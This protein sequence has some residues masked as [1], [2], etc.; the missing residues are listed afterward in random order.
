MLIN[1]VLALIL[2]QT[3]YITFSAN[4]PVLFRDQRGQVTGIHDLTVLFRVISVSAFAL[5]TLV[6]ARAAYLSFGKRPEPDGGRRF[7]LRSPFFAPGGR[8][9]ICNVTLI[10]L[11]VWTGYA[12]ME[13][14]KVSKTNADA[15][16]CAAIL[17]A[18]PIF[19]LAILAIGKTRQF[20]KP[21]WNR[22]PLN[23][24]SD[25]LQ[26]LFISTLCALGAFFGSLPRVY[27][28]AT[29]GFWVA[30]SFASTF[31]GLLI[32]QI[33]AYR[34]FADRITDAESEQ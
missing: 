15:I 34:L 27:G 30:A 31:L 14:R 17:F 12:E 13:S 22:F 28:S 11:S 2:F 19:V 21:K 9:T 29:H 18:L 23:W 16:L 3:A 26:V 1:V 7:S 32:G 20:R 33:L 6:L 24:S 25:P 8:W 10:I 5:G 4:Q